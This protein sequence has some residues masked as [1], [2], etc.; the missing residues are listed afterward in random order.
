MDRLNFVNFLCRKQ[1]AVG[2]TLFQSVLDEMNNL[3]C[4]WSGQSDGNLTIWQ[5][6]NLTIWWQSGGNLTDAWMAFASI[7][8][9]L[10]PILNRSTYQPTKTEYQNVLILKLY[11]LYN[12]CERPYKSGRDQTTTTFKRNT[13][14]GH[15]CRDCSWI[16]DFFFL[17]QSR[18]TENMSKC[19]Y[20]WTTLRWT[21]NMLR[22]ALRWNCIEIFSTVVA[23]DWPPVFNLIWRL[24]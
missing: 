10:R 9:D 12:V 8:K 7:V 14:K 11:H 20:D 19:A 6:D 1:P 18:W 4:S 23:T 17:I 16:L 3:T 24:E 2:F 15:A 22:C 5:S 21:E 13:N